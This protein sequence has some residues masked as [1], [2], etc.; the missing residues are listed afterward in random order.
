MKTSIR[1]LPTLPIR[2]VK[3]YITDM[4]VTEAHAGH[5]QGLAHPGR[6]E[7]I[8]GVQRPHHHQRLGH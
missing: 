7:P 1:K 2:L 5:Q 8:D 3:K 4:K 6:V